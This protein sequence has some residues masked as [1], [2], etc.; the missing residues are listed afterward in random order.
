MPQDGVD[1]A[2][3]RLVALLRVG[4]REQLCRVME[5][6]EELLLV[7]VFLFPGLGHSGGGLLPGGDSRLNLITPHGDRKQEA[8]R[9][10]ELSERLCWRTDGTSVGVW[11]IE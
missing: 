10:Q 6:I 4:T 3:H 8:R 11:D 2:Q 5:I 1:L 9:L 7:L